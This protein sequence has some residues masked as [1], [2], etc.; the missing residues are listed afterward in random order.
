MQ[1]VAAVQDNSGAGGSQRQKTGSQPWAGPNKQWVEKKPLQDQE[2]YTMESAMDQLCRWHTPNPARPAIH[3]T[4]DCSWTKRLMERDMMKDARDQGFETLPPPP[5]LT[6][7]NA[8][9]V[10]PQP[11]R[12]QQQQEVHQ[13]AQGNNHAPPPA[14]LG[15]NVYQDSD[16]C[17]V[18]FVTEPR[19]RQSMHRRSMEVNA[20]IPAVP[21]YMMW[22]DQEITWSFKDHP[23]VMPNPGGYALVVDPIMHGP[24]SRVRFSKCWWTME[25]TSTSC[26]GIPCIR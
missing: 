25:A 9:P 10:Y 13:V 22:S 14:P 8:Q 12:P 2:K 17:C 18:V 26:T 4:K 23:K 3:L 21:K 7:A 20:V 1:Q 15:R 11:N 24:S 19:D 16:M 5:P 6:G